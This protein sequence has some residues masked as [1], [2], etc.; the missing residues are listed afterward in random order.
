MGF[1]GERG[2]VFVRGEVGSD[3]SGGVDCMAAANTEA[4]PKGLGDAVAKVCEVN[5]GGEEAPG[6]VAKQVSDGCVIS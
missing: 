5:D 2:T 1:E 4:E 3:E 6:G